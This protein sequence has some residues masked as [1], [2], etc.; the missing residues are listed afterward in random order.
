ML[1]IH[2]LSDRGSVHHEAWQGV[3]ETQQEGYGYGNRRPLHYIQALRQPHRKL[4]AS[5][6]DQ[7]QVKSWQKPPESSLRVRSHAQIQ[8]QPGLYHQSQSPYQPWSDDVTK[9][10]Q[11]MSPLQRIH[12][13]SMPRSFDFSL[14]VPF[15]NFLGQNKET[16]STTKGSDLNSGGSVGAG[17]RPSSIQ[18]YSSFDS[19]SGSD[20]F[21]DKG[22]SNYP[23]G[24]K[25]AHDVSKPSLQLSLSV[26]IPPT[27]ASPKPFSSNGGYLANLQR[28]GSVG[29]V[30][31]SYMEPAKPQSSSTQSGS[32]WIF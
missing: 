2:V 1:T 18:I 16:S 3:R 7:V 23:Y 8:N 21:S 29:F 14:K 26:P 24:G 17:L 19:P 12:P 5:V 10:T 30:Q 11:E 28:P 22:S 31:N 15:D 20:G 25:N 6:Y 9:W 4:Q 32:E 13:L 27:T